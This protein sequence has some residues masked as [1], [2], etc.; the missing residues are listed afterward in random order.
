MIMSGGLLVNCLAPP[1]R[2]S[3]AF[4]PKAP[5]GEDIRFKNPAWG[6]R[7]GATVSFAEIPCKWLLKPY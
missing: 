3:Q 5:A 6:T 7:Y 1:P 2:V 4:P